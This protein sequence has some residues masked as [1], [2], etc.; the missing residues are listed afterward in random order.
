MY[1]AALIW[2]RRF[3]ESYHGLTCCLSELLAAYKP[4]FIF[5]SFLVLYGTPVEL[6]MELEEICKI[7]EAEVWTSTHP[8]NDK[9]EK[10]FSSDLM[11]DV[12]TLLTDNLLLITGLNNVQTVRTAEMADIYHILFVR[13]KRP[14]D[15][16][17]QLA[18]EQQIVLLSTSYSMFK[19][20]GLLW[21]AG[22]SPVY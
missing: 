16:M 14:G 3:Q 11:S 15:K 21:S 13:G 12:L 20:S 6:R 17:I 4:A 10:A 18:E 8:P 19:T 1:Q 5:Y 2:I 9:I 22:L 7:V